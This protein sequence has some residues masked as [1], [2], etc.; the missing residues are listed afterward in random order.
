MKELLE[1]HQ[2][3]YD[4]ADLGA[5][6]YDGGVH[7]KHRLIRYHDY[8]VDRVSAGERVL[9]VG[10]GKGELAYDLVE[11]SGAR[12]VGIDNNPYYLAFARDR[13][14]HPDLSFVETD[15]LE[16][17]PSAPFDVVILSNVLEHFDDRVGLLRR[18]M[19]AA[20][21]SRVL[22]RV[23]VWAR[24]WIVPLREELGLRAFSDTTH[25]TEYDPESFR[26][27]L[28]EAGLDVTE[29]ELIWGEIWATARPSSRAV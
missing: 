25:Y 20:M 2:D 14:R 7:A 9:D 28:A 3:T 5:I 22:L 26:A 17:L 16:P 13:F 23:P 21:P 11:R 29:L 18:I 10:C 27:E 1:L 19:A 12:V 6:A 24:D 8:F 4:R 15:I